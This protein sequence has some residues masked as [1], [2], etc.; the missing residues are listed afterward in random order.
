MKSLLYSQSSNGNTGSIRDNDK[1]FFPE[2]EILSRAK[3]DA[4]KLESNRMNKRKGDMSKKVEG[5][6]VLLLLYHH[7]H[8]HHHHH[9][10]HHHYHY[11]YCY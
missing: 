8:H 5:M 2:N 4:K 9:H 3:S 7:Y 11:Y 6:T 10:Y 1:L